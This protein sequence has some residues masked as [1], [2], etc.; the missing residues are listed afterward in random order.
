MPEWQ[1]GI[2]TVLSAIPSSRIAISLTG[3]SH[4]RRTAE[5]L[6]EAINQAREEE[7]TGP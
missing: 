3:K 7:E 6:V 1:L 5:Q 4:D 2:M